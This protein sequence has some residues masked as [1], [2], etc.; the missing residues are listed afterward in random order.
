MKAEEGNP[1]GAT[2]RSKN[3]GIR[4]SKYENSET[5]RKLGSA[6]GRQSRGRAEKKRKWVS[7][8]EQPFRDFLIFTQKIKRNNKS[9]NFLKR[10]GS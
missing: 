3:K 5:S 1:H 2:R 9:R 6:P 7:Q 4:A 10:K 8:K